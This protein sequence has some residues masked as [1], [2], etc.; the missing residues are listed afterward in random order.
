MHLSI[1]VD[2]EIDEV[3]VEEVPCTVLNMQFFDRLW[4]CGVV[5]ESGHIIKC[6]DEPYGDF[7]IS[8]KLRE[9]KK[10]SDVSMIILPLDLSPS[11]PFTHPPSLSLSLSQC[12]ISEESE[13]YSVF[14]E[15]ERKEFIFKLFRHL[16]LGGRV[17]QVRTTSSSK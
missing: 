11:L 7:V 17:N 3:C 6:F 12:L 14:S 13:L 16:Q 10:G 4:K 15:D 8:D 5:R 9:V 1:L 2:K